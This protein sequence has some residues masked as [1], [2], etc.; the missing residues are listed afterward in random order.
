MTLATMSRATAAQAPTNVL[1]ALQFLHNIE[2]LQVELHKALAGESTPEQNAAFAVVRAQLGAVPETA[3]SLALIKQQ[4]EAHIALLGSRISALGGTPRA[5][6]GADFTFS[7]RPTPT[8]G[9]TTLSATRT[10]SGATA[11]STFDRLI[12]SF[13]TD[14]FAV[15]QLIT[16]TG[17][18]TANNGSAVV[19]AVTATTLTVTRSPALTTELAGTGRTVRVVDVFAEVRTD[20]ASFLMLAQFVK[21]VVARAYLGQV[22]RLM[23][24]DAILTEVM[25][26]QAVEARHSARIRIARNV[27]GHK[28][29]IS[30]TTSGITFTGFTG[31]AL[32]AANAYAARAYTGEGNTLQKGIDMG[33]LGSNTGGT[34]GVTEA[35]DEPLTYDQVV[36]ALRNLVLGSTAL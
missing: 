29:W 30:T 17:F 19:S 11:I 27:S 32:T 31:A 35:F 23:S 4:D 6:T 13:I 22:E 28:P 21:D 34:A 14:G 3:A 9:S 16:A 7:G 8:T 26:M 1:G 2:S 18:S 33:G 12:G 36:S 25:R 15:G 5:Y 20:L 10:G 24:D